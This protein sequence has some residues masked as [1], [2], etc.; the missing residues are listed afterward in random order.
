MIAPHP[1]PLSRARERGGRPNQG[2][3]AA[4]ELLRQGLQLARA[5][6]ALRWR[7]ET[8]GLYMP[9]LPEA[10]P[11]WRVNGRAL[12]AFLA[13]LPRYARW[14]AAMRALRQEGAA[15]YW[16][17]E[18]GT[19]LRE[20]EDWLDKSYQPSAVSRQLP[21]SVAPTG[22]GVTIVSQPHQKADG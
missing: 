14:L 16:R 21:T 1:Q 17:A 15:G 12:G 2:A 6:R 11:W 13:Q 22:G 9:S 3:R 19:S 5:P 20:W 8:F 4:L 18:A 7:L 10:R